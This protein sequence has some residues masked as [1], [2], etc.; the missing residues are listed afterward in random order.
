MK[1]FRTSRSL[2][3]YKELIAVYLHLGE[4]LGFNSS[5]IEKAYIDKNEVNYKRQAEGY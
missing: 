4:M 5:Q 2:A 1:Q 3:D